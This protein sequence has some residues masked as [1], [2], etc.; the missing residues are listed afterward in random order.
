[1]ND[2]KKQ[3]KLIKLHQ[4]QKSNRNSCMLTNYSKHV[5]SR[6][7]IK[8]LKPFASNGIHFQLHRVLD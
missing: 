1:M 3:I 6:S 4:Q 2:D 8:L 5:R 7:Q